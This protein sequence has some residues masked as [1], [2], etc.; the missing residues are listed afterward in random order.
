V[1]LNSEPS[2]SGS[3]R[4][5]GDACS[6]EAIQPSLIYTSLYKPPLAAPTTIYTASLF[7]ANNMTFAAPICSCKYGRE[8]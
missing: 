8:R 6:S 7:I 1:S 4:S 3:V 2:C 5:F